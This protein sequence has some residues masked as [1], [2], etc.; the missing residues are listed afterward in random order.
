M[1]QALPFLRVKFGEAVWHDSPY[2]HPQL[3]REVARDFYNRTPTCQRAMELLLSLETRKVLVLVGERR[4][5]KTSMLKL[6]LDRVRNTEDFIAVEVPWAGIDAVERL[7]Q[8]MLS[9][10]YHALALDNRD[11]WEIIQAVRSFSE[12]NAVL[13]KIAD[14]FLGKTFVFG[15]DEF[16]SI[17]LEQVRESSQQTMVL[18][19]V[20]TLVESSSLPV[21][22]IL[23]TVKE[24]SQIETSRSSALISRSEPFHLEPFPEPDL[25]EMIS[26]IGTGVSDEE[27]AGT[28]SLSGNWPYFAKAVLYH[29]VQLPEGATRLAQARNKAVES[30]SDTWAHIYHEHWD[31]AAKAVVLLLAWRNK[32]LTLAEAKLVGSEVA[33]AASELVRR[34]YLT[35]E[36]DGYRFRI[37]L[38]PQWLRQWV[39]FEEQAHKYLRDILKRLERSQDPWAGG[40]DEVIEVT[41]EDLR[42]RGF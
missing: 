32:P 8:E 24:I 41:R 3:W 23:T 42:R 38:L 36:D 33:I 7:M 6:L 22:V 25:Q 18:G 19:L 11:L 17:V 28:S 20:S 14:D 35:Q 30:V 1:S 31:D 29:L 27:I 34:G 37:G 15:I 21:K 5:G 16:D 10:L 13:A 39:R 9:G 12:F 26:D 40:E 2:T 4:A